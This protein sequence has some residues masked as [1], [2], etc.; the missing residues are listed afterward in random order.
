MPVTVVILRLFISVW[1]P[2]QSWL[3][4]FC[5]RAWLTAKSTVGCSAWM[6]N[7]LAPATVRNTLAVSRNCLAG[8]QPRCRHVPP[9]LSFSTTATESPAPAA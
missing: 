6:P 9:T 7:S 2:F 8:M 3:T 5:L 1:R 4:T